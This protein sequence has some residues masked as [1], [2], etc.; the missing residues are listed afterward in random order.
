[1][2]NRSM[3]YW[4]NMKWQST[5]QHMLLSQSCFESIMG[6]RIIFSPV[7]CPVGVSQTYLFYLLNLFW[8]YWQSKIQTLMIYLSKWSHQCLFA[9]SQVSQVLKVSLN[10]ASNETKPQMSS[11]LTSV[12][13]AVFSFSPWLLRTELVWV[14]LFQTQIFFI[15]LSSLTCLFQHFP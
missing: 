4:S 11:F 12:K 10:A 1:M 7:D 13:T 3:T 14:F 9:C 15:S 8:F 5:C 6:F 2:T